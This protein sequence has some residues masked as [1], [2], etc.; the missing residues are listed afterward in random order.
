MTENSN[1]CVEAVRLPSGNWVKFI[2]EP[3]VKVTLVSGTE[4]PVDIIARTMRAYSNH[5]EPTG[6]LNS[7]ERAEWFLEVLKTPL[8]TPLE[9]VYFT[10]LINDIPRAITHQLVRTRIGASVVQQSLRFAGTDKVYNIAVPRSIGIRHEEQLQLFVD[11]NTEALL[12]YEHMIEQGVPIQDARGV[13]PINFCT[14]LY[15]GLCMKTFIYVFNQRF[16]CQAQPAWYTLVRLMR[17]ELTEAYGTELTDA[18]TAPV[19]R[20]ESCGYKS[21]V[22]RPCLWKNGKTDW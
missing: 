12:A 11:S 10:F 15:W 19:E 8:A 5:Y 13:L 22:D 18:I 2:L 16:C 14:H 21:K 1:T 7:N 4:D 17:N 9:M 6:P 3:T 20:N